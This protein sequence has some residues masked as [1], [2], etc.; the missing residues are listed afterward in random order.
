MISKKIQD[1]ILQEDFRGMKYLSEF[2]CENYVS[3]ASD[4]LLKSE[5]EILI[6]TGFYILKAK[7]PETDGPPGAIAISNALNKIGLKTSFVTDEYSYQVVKA[8]AGD[9]DV[10][11]FPITSHRE[12]SLFAEKLLNSKNIGAILSIER[13]GLLN[14]G[15]YRNW[16]GEDFSEYNAKIDHLFDQHPYTIGIGDGG[17]EI[18]M[19]NLKKVIPTIKNLPKDPCV[20]TTK[21]LIIA[22]CSNWGGY[23]L[24][25]DMSIKTGLNLLPTVDQA[26]QWVKKGVENGAVEGM[27]GES[28][29]WVDGRSPKED[30]VCIS[31]LIELVETNL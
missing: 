21:E 24:V 29:D 9:L 7:S 17:N 18:G 28:K 22:S 26:Y 2:M 6:V 30:S 3:N 16:R 25:A 15:T 19:G 1:I 23:G 5:G 8:L 10:I 20:T 13:A 11:R 4:L 31:D 27:S 14:D 12:S